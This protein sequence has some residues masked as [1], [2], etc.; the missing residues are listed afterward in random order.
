M[1]ETQAMSLLTHKEL[2]GQ[3]TKSKLEDI[4]PEEIFSKRL[5][6]ISWDTIIS[7]LRAQPDHVLQQVLDAKDRKTWEMREHRLEKRHLYST[8]QRQKMREEYVDEYKENVTD[9]R[10]EDIRYFKVS[11]DIE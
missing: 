9:E 6:R 7:T 4:L 10:D 8:N 3:L 11:T 2:T 1:N 5:Y